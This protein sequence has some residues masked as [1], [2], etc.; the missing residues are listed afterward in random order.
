[1]QGGRKNMK[2]YFFENNKI[3][4]FGDIIFVVLIQLENP[5]LIVLILERSLKT[6]TKVFNF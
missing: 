1:M 5:E 6:K 2:M 4:D 3:S